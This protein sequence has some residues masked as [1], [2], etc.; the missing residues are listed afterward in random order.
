L[1]PPT[2][3]FFRVALISIY[4]DFWLFNGNGALYGTMDGSGTEEEAPY[5]NSLPGGTR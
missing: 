4:N 2:P 3:A 1:K 5:S